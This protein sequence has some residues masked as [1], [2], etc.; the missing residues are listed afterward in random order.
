M[1]LGFD[2]STGNCC[3]P[4]LSFWK[5]NTM[6]GT[7]ISRAALALRLDCLDAICGRSACSGVDFP[8]PSETTT[9]FG[10][11]SD[12][13]MTLR[14]LKDDDED[15]IGGD[16]LDGGCG[17]KREREMVESYDVLPQKGSS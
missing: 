13:M 2:L 11:K 15:D 9:L 14:D 10:R 17:G 3:V 5:R 12:A 6:S 1:L 16:E 8:E 4:F 7:L